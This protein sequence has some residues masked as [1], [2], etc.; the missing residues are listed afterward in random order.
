M[1]TH[2]IVPSISKHFLYAVSMTTQTTVPNFKVLSIVL[3]K[4]LIKSK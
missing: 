1:S 4:L 3:K 2:T